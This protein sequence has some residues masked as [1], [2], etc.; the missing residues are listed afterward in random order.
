MVQSTIIY[1]NRQRRR[2][3]SRDE[4]IIKLAKGAKNPFQFLSNFP[5]QVE[6]FTYCN[7]PDASSSADQI[8]S[9]FTFNEK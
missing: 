3:L 1:S 6:T 5:D 4:Y 8:M 9:Y 2:A 7:L